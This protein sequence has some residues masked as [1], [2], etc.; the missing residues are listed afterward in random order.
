MTLLCLFLILSQLSSFFS[1]P[2]SLLFLPQF[3]LSSL[4]L[5]FALT[6][7]LSLIF[8]SLLHFPPLLLLLCLPL[9]LFHLFFSLSL[10]HYYFKSNSVDCVIN[11]L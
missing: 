1:Y 2:S 5:T 9:Y 11:A 8:S 10:S 7:T 4:S 6:Y 3:L